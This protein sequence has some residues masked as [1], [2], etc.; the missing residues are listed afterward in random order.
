[1][2]DRYQR[3]AGYIILDR[4][5]PDARDGLKPVQRRILWAMHINR[6]IPDSDYVKSA[7][8]VGETMGKFHPHGDASIYDALVRMAQE[9]KLRYLLVDGHG[10]FGSV[11]DDPPAAMRYTEARMAPLAMELLRDIDAETVNF[12]PNFDDRRE[13]PTVLPARFPNLLVNGASGVSAGFATE[14]PP[15]N[16]G[17]VID[18]AMALMD[19]PQITVQEIMRHLKGPDFPTGGIVMGAEG[20]KEAYETGKGKIA[21]RARSGVERVKGGKEQIVVTEIPCGVIKAKLVKEI[22]DLRLDRKVEGIA[23]VRDETDRTG[24]R[25]VIELKKDAD[26]RGILNYLFKKTSL[27]VNYYFNMVAIANRTP[28]QMGVREL[29]SAYIDHQK[30]VVTRRS[31]YDLARAKDRAHV[32]EGLMRAISIL[33]EVI[34]TIRS[35]K[36]R[37]DAQKN[38]ME[39]FAFSERQAEAILTLQLYRLTNLEIT[40]LAKELKELQKTIAGLEA[41]LSS[42]KKL[43]DVIKKELLE[44]KEKYADPRRSVIQAEVEEIKVSVE[45]MVASEDVV[46][47]V[48]N[49][50][51]IKRTSIKSYQRS[52]ADLED[53]G[54]KDADFVRFLVSSNTTETVLLLT[55]RGTAYSLPVHQLPEAKWKERGSALVNVISL[56]KDDRVVAL[57]PVKD[58]AA[59]LSLI[60]FTAKGLVKKTDLSEY[61]T[62]RSTGIVAIKLAPDDRV[63]AVICSD[64]SGEILQST[65]NGMCIRYP[66]TEVSSMGRNAAGV[67][68]IRLAPGDQVLAAQEVKAGQEVI[69]MTD[70]GKGKRVTLEEFPL[71]SRAGKGVLTGKFPKRQKEV[72]A[73]MEVVD[74]SQGVALLVVQKSGR[75]TRLQSD[76]IP[77]VTREKAFTPLVDV[78]MGD[79]IASMVPSY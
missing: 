33:D 38:L 49:Q 64:G 36:N 11:D 39:K 3:Y 6:I 69:L 12:Q 2:G 48:T 57:I 63:V 16:L 26:A 62:Q 29:L 44:I 66:G 54:T 32:V 19:K 46:V 23:E 75:I 40:T 43:M 78:I 55:A 72:L 77:A 67:K 30:E 73:A 56:P 71:Q 76:A 20:I 24:M 21:L 68:A 10:N 41:I 59:E 51:Y 5:I 35:S 28:R 27:Q 22:D 42:E 9:W 18:A 50:G 52:G 1:M 65:I 74:A 25:I 13:E 15:H 79:C 7:T 53:A 8:V 34:A 60:F 37:A 4:A 58:F 61:A 14:I 47:A 45:V 31:R 70:W 17:E